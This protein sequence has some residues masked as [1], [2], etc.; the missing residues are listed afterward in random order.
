METNHE[1]EE[2]STINFYDS[3]VGTCR[4]LIGLHLHR[5]RGVTVRYLSNALSGDISVGFCVS[6]KGAMYG[7]H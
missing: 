1:F 2:V 6:N 4:M 5:T 7:G 3:D